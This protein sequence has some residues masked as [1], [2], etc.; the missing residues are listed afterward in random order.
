MPPE[1]YHVVRSHIR[2]NPGTKS[3]KTSGWVLAALLCAA[4]WAWG[5]L[6]GSADGS[7]THPSTPAPTISA[8]S[9]AG[10]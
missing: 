6:G 1:G 8:A 2:R 10:R 3:K 7:T 9:A 5:H 4:V